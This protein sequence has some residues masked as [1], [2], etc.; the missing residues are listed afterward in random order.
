MKPETIERIRQGLLDQIERVEIQQEVLSRRSGDKELDKSEK[1][2]TKKELS[3]LKKSLGYMRNCE[4]ELVKLINQ[5]S[6]S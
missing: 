5:K 6:H 1:K 3:G 4:K 2:E